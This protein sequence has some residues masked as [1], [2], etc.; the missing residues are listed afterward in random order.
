MTL[1]LA[2]PQTL[3]QVRL[4]AKAMAAAGATSG[5]GPAGTMSQESCQTPVRARG[6]VPKPAPGQDNSQSPRVREAERQKQQP[7][8]LFQRRVL[9]GIEVQVPRKWR[10]LPIERYRPTTFEEESKR[11]F[12]VLRVGGDKYLFEE[13][14]GSLLEGKVQDN[15]FRDFR[16]VDRSPS[17]TTKVLAAAGSGSAESAVEQTLQDARDLQ[18]QFAR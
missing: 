7:R 16:D 1:G 11:K 12:R 2:A 9:R 17:W 15:H 4:A 10:E 13:G 18:A 3:R 14:S 5:L 8:I 6:H